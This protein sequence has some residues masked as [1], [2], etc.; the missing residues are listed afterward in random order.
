[1]PN[2]TCGG[3]RGKGAQVHRKRSPTYSIYLVTAWFP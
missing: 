3:V 1:M 2:G